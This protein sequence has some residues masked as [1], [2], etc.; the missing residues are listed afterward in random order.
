[1]V[2]KGLKKRPAG[3]SVPTK[4]P[5]K[6]KPRHADSER[7]KRRVGIERTYYGDEK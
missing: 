5:K 4:S 2:K 1:L 7:K 6:K 3:A